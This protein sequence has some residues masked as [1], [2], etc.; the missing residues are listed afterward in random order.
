MHHAYCNY[1]DD[2]MARCF[3]SK[4]KEKGVILMEDLAEGGEESFVDMKEI[5]RV[6]GGGVE[7][8]YMRMLLKVLAHFHGACVVWLGRE[9]LD[10]RVRLHGPR[11]PR[12]QPRGRLRHLHGDHARLRGVHA[13]GRGEVGVWHG[14]FQ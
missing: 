2:D 14:L 5:E 3:V 4:P 7:T 8:A 1:Q 6:A 12:R 9:H 13:G 11:L 10:H